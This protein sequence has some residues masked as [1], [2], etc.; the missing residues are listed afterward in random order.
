MQVP[1]L[2]FF[3]LQFSICTE[4]KWRLYQHDFEDNAQRQCRE[5]RTDPAHQRPRGRKRDIF[6]VLRTK[7]RH[8]TFQNR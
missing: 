3:S 8:S 1:D 5:R 4:T 7:Q 6:S 2:R